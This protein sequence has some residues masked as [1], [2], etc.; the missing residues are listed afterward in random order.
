MFCDDPK[1]IV[2]VTFGVPRTFVL[3]TYAE[4]GVGV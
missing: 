4:A 2:S 3:K 1:T